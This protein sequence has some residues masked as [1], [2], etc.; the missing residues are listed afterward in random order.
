MFVG[1]CDQLMWNDD[2]SYPKVLWSGLSLCVHIRVKRVENEVERFLNIK[3]KANFTWYSMQHKWNLFF[4][5]KNSELKQ[6]LG[7]NSTIHVLQKNGFIFNLLRQVIE[8]IPSILV[9]RYREENGIVK[10]PSHR[11]SKRWWI[12]ELRSSLLSSIR[13]TVTCNED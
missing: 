11:R 3:L 8:K 6:C 12:N 13:S 5:F 9:L 1:F 10:D 7:P 4:T 2:F